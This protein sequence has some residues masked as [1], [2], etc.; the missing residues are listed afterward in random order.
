MSQLVGRPSGSNSSVNTTVSPTNETG[1]NPFGVGG[2]SSIS[3]DPVIDPNVQFAA[4]G[5]A[6][7]RIVI[8]Y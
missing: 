4:I 2:G 5:G 1:P 7:G 8:R 6:A 3:G